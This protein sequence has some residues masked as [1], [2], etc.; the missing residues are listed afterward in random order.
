L[1]VFGARLR[2]RRDV[3]NSLTRTVSV[4]SAA[5]EAAREAL[6]MPKF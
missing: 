4:V 3:R 5:A 6:G 1:M 2:A